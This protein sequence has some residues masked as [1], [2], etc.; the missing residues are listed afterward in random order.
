MWSEFKEKTYETAFVGELRL[1]TNAV[2]APDQCD[3]SFLGFDAAALVPW[4]FLPPFAPYV[5]FRRWRHHVGISASEINNFGRE[6]NNRLP[7]FKLNLFLQFKRPE[8]LVRRNAAEWSFW[9]R[10]YF[11][12]AIGKRQQQLLERILTVGG[13][14]TAVAY[15]VPAFFK[16]EDLFENQINKSIIKNSNVLSAGLLNGHSKCTF[17]EPGNFGIGHSEPKEIESPTLQQLISEGE[18]LDG[19]PFTQHMKTTENDI[20]LALEDDKEGRDRL[21]LARRAILGGDITDIYPRA[22]GTWFDAILTVVAFGS[23]SGLRV[24]AIA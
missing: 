18:S 20:K 23:A 10:S 7:P 1:L 15:A 14:R 11:R 19:L 13:N 22:M 12:Y 9:Q 8:Y 21:D 16:S 3:E 2:Y 5:R 24:C 6:L 17:S 4:E